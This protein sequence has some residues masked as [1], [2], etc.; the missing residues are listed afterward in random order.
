MTWEHDHF[1]IDLDEVDWAEIDERIDPDW[2]VSQHG[3]T[4]EDFHRWLDDYRNVEQLRQRGATQE[5]FESLR[6]SP[7]PDDQRLWA[8]YSY[9]YD[10]DHEHSDRVTATWSDGK[11][12]VGDGTHR[13]S[14]AKQRGFTHLPAAVHAPDQAT[15]DQLKS[16]DASKP[17]AFPA[18]PTADRE[19]S[20]YSERKKPAEKSRGPS[21]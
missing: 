4:R 16:R 19:R 21:R 8:A 18:R 5:S 12:D 20:L 6:D 11:Y 1:L 15:L 14:L 2:T 3:Y 10:P 9:A 7:D 13:V 17:I